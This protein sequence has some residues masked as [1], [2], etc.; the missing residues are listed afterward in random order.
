MSTATAAPRA[1]RGTAPRPLPGP[2]RPLLALAVALVGGAVVLSPHWWAD[3][4]ALTGVS[5]DYIGLYATAWAPFGLLAL[6][7]GWRGLL[8][9]WMT[10]AALPILA[11]VTLRALE[12]MSGTVFGLSEAA[13]PIVLAVIVV[14]LWGVDVHVRLRPDVEAPVS[15]PLLLALGLLVALVLVGGR[16]GGVDSVAELET[17]TVIFASI[18]VEA[19]PFVLLGALMSGLIEVFVS[20]RAFDRVSRLPLRL[21][22]PGL[23]LCGMAMPVCECGSVPVARRLILRGVHPGAG[24][25]FMLA[26]P[27]LNPVVLFSTWVAYSGQ[28]ALLM[29][30]ARAGL[31]LV[32][33]T[34]S[35]LLIARMGAGRLLERSGAHAHHH[36]GDGRVRQ[37]MDHLSADFFFMGKFVIA[38]AALAAAMQ[39]LVPQDVFTGVLTTPLVGAAL[40]M[41]F[42]FLLSLCSEADAFVAISF[43]QFPIGAQLAFLVFGPVL[44][45]KLALLYA[46][47]FGWAFVARL[48]VITIPIVLG[49]SMLVQ[50]VAG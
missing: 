27:I 32:L 19:L 35:G 26:A 5:A 13:A 23:A 4:W 41:A 29:V 22:V 34:A 28:D 10:A 36:H 47:T 37:V 8:S 24:V 16:L 40:L 25:A 12:T 15:V 30:A 9:P 3:A 14:I 44:D 31:G 38:G 7:T 48:A 50:A 39:T 33:A 42:A 6:L 18:A 43:V 11:A 45:I 46:A 17:F 1:A 21:Q 20:D 49:G 2:H